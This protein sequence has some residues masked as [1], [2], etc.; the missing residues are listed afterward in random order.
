MALHQAFDW[1]HFQILWKQ[2]YIAEP[3]WDPKGIKKVFIKE[4]KAIKGCTRTDKDIKKREKAEMKGL[5]VAVTD[6]HD[7]WV[8]NDDFC[9]LNTSKRLN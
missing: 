3:Q 9:H 8:I 7:L 6:L 4:N 5:T 1:I 2:N